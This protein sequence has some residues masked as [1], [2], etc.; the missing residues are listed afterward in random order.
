MTMVHTL[1]LGSFYADGGAM[2][3]AVPKRAW[4][5]RYFSDDENRCLLA[6]RGLLVRVGRRTVVVDCGVGQKPDKRLAYYNWRETRPMEEALAQH[7][8]G[9]EEVTDVIFTHL[10]FDHC[11][12]ATRL[13]DRGTV[14]PTFPRAIHWTSR[15]H[16]VHAQRPSLLEADSF[17]ADNTDVLWK[18]GLIRLVDDEVTTLGD[19]ISLYQCDGHTLGQLAP[20]FDLPEGAALFPGDVIPIA[21]HL[22]A[23]W[24]S[25]Y[26]IEPV[27]SLTSKQLLIDLAKQRRAKI[28]F[29]HDA[30]EAMREM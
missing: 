23:V 25:A 28:Y 19:G 9:V 12:G 20:F 4:S 27:R 22:S 1:E 8:V 2:F 29:C 15:R 3:G 6:I 13:D 11:G 14:V 18:N 17:F 5:R 10:H 26:D 21:A 7:G 30:V 16:W 24:I